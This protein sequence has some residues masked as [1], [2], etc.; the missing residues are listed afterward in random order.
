MNGPK[1]A[2]P[3]AIKNVGGHEIRIVPSAPEP[4][5]FKLAGNAPFLVLGPGET[6]WLGPDGWT[7]VKPE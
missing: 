4:G 3:N 2:T 5:G 7:K 1:R 6:M